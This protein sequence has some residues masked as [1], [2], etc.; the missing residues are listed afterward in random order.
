[1]ETFLKVNN[2][3]IKILVDNPSS[4]FLRVGEGKRSA[5]GDYSKSYRHYNQSWELQTGIYKREK[6]VAIKRLLEGQGHAFFLQEGS[7]TFK[8]SKG[9]KPSTLTFSQDVREIKEV[10]IKFSPKYQENYTIIIWRENNM[11]VSTRQK[12]YYNGEE[13]SPHDFFSFTA[14]GLE[15]EDSGSNI[16]NA[17]IVLPYICT[18]DMIQAFYNYDNYFSELPKIHISGEIYPVECESATSDVEGTSF[19]YSY[20]KPLGQRIDFTITLQEEGEP[21]R[22]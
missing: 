3:P 15:I 6:V 4:D 13:S 17:I 2:Y 1:M 9:L 8:S 21:W 20:H 16:Y 7:N 22:Y 18:K 10:Y 14:S 19:E 11:Y 12:D 5:Q